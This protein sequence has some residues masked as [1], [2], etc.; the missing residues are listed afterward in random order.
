VKCFDDLY[1]SFEAEMQAGSIRQWTLLLGEN[2]TG[3]STLLKAIALVTSGSDALS[4]LLT[5]PTDWI[6]YGKKECVISALLVTKKMEEKEITLSIQQEYSRSD[7]IIHNKESLQWLDKA[8]KESARD[9]FLVGF[10]AYRHLSSNDSF[11]AKRSAFLNVRAQ[12]VAT[13]FSPDA[14]LNPLES[15]AMSLDYQHE[16]GLDIVRDVLNDFLPDISFSRIDKQRGRLLFKTED[17]IVPLRSLGDGYQ[18][19]AAWIGDLLYRVMQTYD[20]YPAKSDNHPSPLEASGLLLI[21]EVDLHFHPKWQQELFS[22]L[23]TRLPN[24][25]LI[26][27]THSPM[28]AQ[29]VAPCDLYYVRRENSRIALEPFTGNP[30]SLL[31]NQM[32][33]S[34]AFGVES[35]ESWQL[36]EK[37]ARYRELRD[38]EQLSTEEK[39]RL[40]QLTVELSERPVGG[41]SNLRLQEEEVELLRQIQ[42][43]LQE[44]KS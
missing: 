11:L 41:R 36:Q 9:Y 20:T 5:E 13:L 17:G 31:V 28:I 30:R 2:G 38:K 1:L 22:F 39:E 6:Q 12:S 24:F 26:I 29:Q 16:T 35:D 40:D 34:E 27:T 10:G 18:S 32:L 23:S 19:V 37:K 33:M 21:D 44:R 14:T 15:W 8:L 7:V 4:D 42:Q 25:Q 43:E 3:K